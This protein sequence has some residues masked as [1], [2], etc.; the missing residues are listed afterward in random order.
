[1]PASRLD[2]VAGALR[3]S[4]GTGVRVDNE[5]LVVQGE[6]RERIARWF[7]ANEDG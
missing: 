6:Q 2:E 4:L 3:T 7:D 5:C 1:V